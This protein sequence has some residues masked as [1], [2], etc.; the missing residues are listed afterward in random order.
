MNNM[1]RPQDQGM[2]MNQDEYLLYVGRLATGSGIIGL[3]GGLVFSLAIGFSGILLI[4]FTLLTGYLFLTG[5]WGGYKLNR[6]FRKFKYRMPTALWAVSRIPV[7]GFGIIAGWIVWGI[8]EH[9]ILLL[10][11]GAEG[12]PGMI[13]SQFILVPK[14]GQGIAD[15]MDY[16]PS[17]VEIGPP[18]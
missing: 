9:F 7:V 11:M 5:F 18:E 15:K 13:L 1:G 16:N 14:I 12:N 17:E 3:V 2:Y 4:F 8:F 10:A 6:W